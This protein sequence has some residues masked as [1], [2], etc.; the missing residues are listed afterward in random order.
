M[1][2]KQKRLYEF[3]PF[4]LDEAERLLQRAGEVVPLTPKALDVLLMLVKQP[5][6]LL[7]K[8]TLL[9]AVWLDSFV[10]E[11]NL[12]DNISRLR[13]VLGEGEN[14]QKFI[15]TVPKS[16]YRFVATVRDVTDEVD[17]V[18]TKLDQGPSLGCTGSNYASEQ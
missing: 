13:K 3:G 10:E 15:E 16:G 11:N 5:G 17:T 18:A 14:G 1:E 9:Q 7:K 2:K 4:R 12:T 8:E 6:R